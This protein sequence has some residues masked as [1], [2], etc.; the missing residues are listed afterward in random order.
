MDAQSL[1]AGK[2]SEFKW[3]SL[4]KMDGS[5]RWCKD[6]NSGRISISDES[7]SRPHLTDDGV[8]WL[9]KD[10]PIQLLQYDYE[11]DSG[12]NSPSLN[13]PVI[14]YAGRSHVTG[15]TLRELMYLIREHDMQFEVVAA[16]HPT[17]NV[18]RMTLY[19]GELVSQ[20]VVKS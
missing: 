15:C 4:V 8:L 18:E 7:G 3:T 17:T 5:H 10:K 1:A 19:A 6:E 2:R 16:K 14:D 20:V 13:I 12:S 9:D 11:P